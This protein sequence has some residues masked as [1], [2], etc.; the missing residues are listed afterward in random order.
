[1]R[2]VRLVG[3]A[4]DGEHVLLTGPEIGTVALRIDDRLKAAVLRDRRLLDQLQSRPSS[5]LSVREMQARLRAGASA[6]AVAEE[7]GVTVEAVRRFAGPVLDERNH[8]AEEVRRIRTKSGRALA[9]AVDPDTSWDAARR[10]DGSWTVSATGAAGVA[11]FTWNPTRRHL[12]AESELAQIAL[13]DPAELAVPLVEPAPVALSIVR[14]PAAPAHVADEPEPVFEEPQLVEDQGGEYDEVVVAE[15]SEPSDEPQQEELIPSITREPKH[16]GVT[17]RQ[18][19]A[20]GVAPGK[21]AT[22]PSWDD[23]LFGTKPPSER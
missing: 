3:M 14:E 9:E 19:E 8:V 7:A 4:D 20:D 21:R 23:I 2:E 11:Q 18:A 1:M 10:D 12:E 17:D 15:E 6:E 5:S 13:A 16:T 22:V